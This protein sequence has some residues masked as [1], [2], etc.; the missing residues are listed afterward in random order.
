MSRTRSTA[1]NT[2][3]PASTSSRRTITMGDSPGGDDGR[4]WDATP[5][6]ARLSSTP[7]AGY[8]AAVRQS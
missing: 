4:R 1:K 5:L 3:T 8:A 7:G 2:S 6:H